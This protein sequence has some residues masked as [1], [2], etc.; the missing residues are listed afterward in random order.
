MTI[1]LN[2]SSGI[3]GGIN[4]PA[5]INLAG[6]SS[7][8]LTGIPSTAKRITVIVYNAVGTNATW[9]VQLGSG[10]LT[11]TGY[12]GSSNLLNGGQSQ[13]GL[14]SSF[15]MYSGA[16]QSQCNGAI[17]N[18]CNIVGT[19]T[20]VCTAIFPYGNNNGAQNFVAGFV[21]LGGTLD[22]VALI[23]GSGTFS[24][25]TLQIFYE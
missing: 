15:G 6:A 9:G 11:T 10:G 2:G 19:N 12:T 14:S 13:G 7:G 25:G 16:T 1:T 5:V 23:T 20:W 3:L 21:T 8:T 4:S 22:R 17:F 18:I 24:S